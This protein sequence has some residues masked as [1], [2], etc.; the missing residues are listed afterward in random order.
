MKLTRLTALIAITLAPLA[1]PPAA[2]AQPASKV[3]RIGVLMLAPLSARPQQW[4]AFR[5]GLREQGYVLGQN[6]VVEFRSAN[7]NLERL[8]ELAMELTNLNVAVIVASGTEATQAAQKATRVIPIV[9]SNTGDPVGSGIVASLARPGANVTGLSL[10]ATELSAK[11]LELLKEAMPGLTRVAVL[12]NP[13]N[14]SVTLKAKE[15]AAAARILGL[16]LQS[17]EARVPADLETQILA[18]ARAQADAL[19]TAD[20]QF[21]SSQRATIIG[22]ASRYRL[23]VMS[24]FREMAEAGGLASY[25]P[26]LPDLARRAASYVDRILKGAKPGDLPV[27]QP[28]TF[29]LVIN[30][31]TAKALGLTIPPAVLARA[32]DIIQ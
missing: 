23:P 4:E 26:S 1:A 16:Q 7:G 3:S 8:A 18:A 25:G 6:I 15:T 14:A 9:M 28:T 21:L 10:V 22:L 19:I 27:E 2:E 17:L 32:D 31:K 11:R 20:D 13:N 30:L 29:E 24:E 5:Q 12:W